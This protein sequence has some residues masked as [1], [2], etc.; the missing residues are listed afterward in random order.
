MLSDAARD[1]GFELAASFMVGDRWSDIEAGRAAGCTT[2][3]IDRPYS[4]RERCTPD[5][6]VTDLSEATRLILAQ[7]SQR[8]ILFSRDPKER[9]VSEARSP[10]GRR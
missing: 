1:F 10:S 4:H 9:A 7:K 6:V 5:H 8:G 3:L 2:F